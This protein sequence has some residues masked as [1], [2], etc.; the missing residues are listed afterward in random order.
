MRA[1]R[2]SIFLTSRWFLVPR[3]FLTNQLIMTGKPEKTAGEKHTARAGKG[4]D[5]L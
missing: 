3:T 2:G 5:Y 4:D 1:T